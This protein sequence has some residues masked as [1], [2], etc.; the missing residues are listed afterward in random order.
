M[1]IL[2]VRQR[3][4]KTGAILVQDVY[5][6]KRIKTFEFRKCD[7]NDGVKIEIDINQFALLANG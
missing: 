6:K 7:T 2:S 4:N 3:P 1:E 5:E